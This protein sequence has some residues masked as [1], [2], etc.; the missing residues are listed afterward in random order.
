M[1]SDFSALI[2]KSVRMVCCGVDL[3]VLWRS[4]NTYKKDTHGCLFLY[5]ER[6]A[7]L[8]ISREC[9]QNSFFM[10]SN[11]SLYPFTKN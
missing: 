1:V 8:N 7:D 6:C 11:I 3:K 2:S 5:M 9:D 10:P 4:A